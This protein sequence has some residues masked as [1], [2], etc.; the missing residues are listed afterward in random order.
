MLAWW[1]HRG[2]ISSWGLGRNFPTSRTCFTLD[3]PV[4]MNGSHFW[5]T[6]TSRVSTW[7]SWPPVYTLCKALW[8]HLAFMIT[9]MTGCCYCLYLA[10]EG[11]SEK[12]MTLMQVPELINDRARVKI[13]ETYVS[14]LVRTAVESPEKP[15][16]R[17]K[18]AEYG[19][20]PSWMEVW[21]LSTV[22]VGEASWAMESWLHFFLL[23]KASDI[24]FP[25]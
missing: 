19:D 12:L 6:F 16:C 14:F 22:A 23:V 5:T 4:T 18:T 11:L 15:A 13:S 8:F 24:S 3:T 9:C 2:K 17:W 20:S 7:Q 1:F 25:I 10:N 21:V